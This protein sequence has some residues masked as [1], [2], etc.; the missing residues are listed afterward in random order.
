M[1][2]SVIENST[3]KRK[4]KKKSLNNSIPTRGLRLLAWKTFTRLCRLC[5]RE[6]ASD[7]RAC[8]G[9]QRPGVP[10]YLQEEKL[11]RDA[12]SFSNVDIG[13]RIYLRV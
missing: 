9:E 2:A 1:A 8:E 5:K 4:K 7:R 13:L 11:A 6:F 12:I 10:R 3:E